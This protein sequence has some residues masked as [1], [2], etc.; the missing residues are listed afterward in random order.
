[1]TPEIVPMTPGIVPGLVPEA[2]GSARWIPS[3]CKA[4]NDGMDDSGSSRV[5]PV[6]MTTCTD[7]LDLLALELERTSRSPAGRRALRRFAS[8][9]IDVGDASSLVDLVRRYHEASTARDPSAR[10]L[11]EQLLVLAPVDEVAAV[12]ALEAIRPALCWVVRRVHG[13]R[14]ASDDQIASIVA[15]AW[16]AICQPPPKHG[17]RARHVVFLTRTWAR[18]AD[19]RRQPTVVLGCA[20][21]LQ[22]I[23]RVEA[24]DPGERPE[25]LL[26]HAVEAGYLTN[27]DAELIALTRGLGI[28]A[29]VL[30]R[31]R[32]VSVKTLLQRRRRAEAAL[33]HGMKSDFRP[34]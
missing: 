16:E 6:P 25:P 30:A 33:A 3:D 7:L 22:R 21:D 4:G 18:T 28:P 23:V 19:R 10:V 26:R 17:P 11:L 24:P 29:R 15:F 2:R 20:D 5:L 9:G 34:R 8:A 13:T 14:D 1:V 12:C 31:D 27:A 32:D